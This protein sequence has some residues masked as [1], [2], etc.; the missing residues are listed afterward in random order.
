LNKRFS[1]EKKTKGQRSGK[2]RVSRQE[3][4]ALEK[5]KGKDWKPLKIGFHPFVQQ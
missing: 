2:G 4:A 1:I 3:K 5:Q